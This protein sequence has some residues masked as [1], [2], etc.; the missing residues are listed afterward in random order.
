MEIL[1]IRQTHEWGNFLKALGWESVYFKDGDNEVAVR[2]KK[3]PLTSIIK[4]Q[5]PNE[6][7]PKLIAEIRR[8]GRDNR[9]FLT[10]LEPRQNSSLDQIIAAK[11]KLDSWPLSAPKT[12][13]LDLTISPEERLKL[14]SK[15]GRYCLR[16]AQKNLEQLK[17][18]LRI[19]VL[20]NPSAN[21]IADFYKIFTLTAKANHFWVPSLSEITAKAQAFGDSCQIF[22]ASE[23]NEPLAGAMVLSTGTHAFYLHAASTP[24]AQE[25]ELPY[26]IIWKILETLKAQGFVSLDL[27]GIYD[28]RYANLTKKWQKFT[29][30]KRF[31][32]RP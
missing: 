3:L 22:L 20:K 27:E 30:F 6:L 32:P 26:A 16:Q 29:V 19:D 5:R 4:V 23:N 12:I 1:D 13:I 15:D 9:A 28:E 7:T 17:D 21:N 31:W 11:F 14:M 25:L 2:V 8:I 24:R 10:K 18:S